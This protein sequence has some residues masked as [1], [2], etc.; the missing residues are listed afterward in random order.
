MKKVKC[1]GVAI[2]VIIVVFIF[3]NPST[4]TMNMWIAYNITEFRPSLAY[5]ASIQSSWKNIV[6]LLSFDDPQRTKWNM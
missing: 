1:I 4:W 6:A 5:M 2:L 3:A